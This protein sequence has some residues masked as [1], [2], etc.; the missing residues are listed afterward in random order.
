MWRERW[1]LA[2]VVAAFILLTSHFWMGA[3][4]REPWQA[5]QYRLTQ[6]L[7]RVA[8]LQDQETWRAQVLAHPSLRW[9]LTF[10]VWTGVVVFGIG[11]VALWRIMRR[12]MRG[13][14]IWPG[15]GTPPPVPWG[16]WGVTKLFAWLV[17]AAAILPG[18]QVVAVRAWHWSAP[19]RYLAATMETLMLDGIAAA[20]VFL[21]LLWPHRVPVGVLGLQRTRLAQRL[22]I[23]LRGYCAWMPL[24]V[25]TVVAVAGV[26]RWLRLEPQP[27]AIVIMLLEES[28]PRLLMVLMGLV[29]VIGPAVEEVVF[30][31]VTY[32]ALRRRWGVRAG[33]VGSAALF[34]A[35]HAD[36]F[37]FAPIFV[38]G[39]LLGWLYEHTGSLVPSIAVHMMHNSVMFLVAMTVRDVLQVVGP[40]A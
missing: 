10:M 6:R 19:D 16:V 33:L 9:R 34:A 24:F 36:P 22:A 13:E 8:D 35:M 38:L 12:R 26:T 27:Q 4:A 23:G 15:E 5:Q 17:C 40:P 25:A 14:P 31:G 2:A 21:L 1:H 18:L 28:R 39:L 37:A 32:A 30:R 29:T 7:G 3:G 20:L 11:C